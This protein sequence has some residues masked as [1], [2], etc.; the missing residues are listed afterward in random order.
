MNTKGFSLI[1]LLVATMIA[2]ILGTLLF[3]AFYQINKFVPAIDNRTN[4]IEKAA[5]VNAQLEKDFAGIIVPNEFYDRSSLRQEA[6]DSAKAT[7][8]RSADKDE[9]AKQEKEAQPKADKKKPL[10][11]IFYSVNKSGMLDKLSFL[12]TSSLQ[13][14]WGPKSGSA[15]PRIVRVM[16]SLKENPASK[17]GK[18]SYSLIRKESPKLEFEEIDKSLEYVLADNIRSLTMDYTAVMIEPEKKQSPNQA[19]KTTQSA[20]PELEIKQLSEWQENVSQGEAKDQNQKQMPLTPQVI[21]MDISFW[22]V[23][24]RRSYPF[25]FTYKIP[26]EFALKKVTEDYAEKMLGTLKEM[27]GHVSPQSQNKPTQM[28]Q[29]QQSPFTF[30]QRRR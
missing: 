12:T 13:V 1:E 27:F 10:E 8:D 5:L 20:R 21:S 4:I 16:Y 2:S 22:D 25:V 11:K 7:T 29:R 15:K 28:A 23:A 14:Y 18:K 30:G 19:Q 24:K 6:S 17:E 3:S 9:K 26:G